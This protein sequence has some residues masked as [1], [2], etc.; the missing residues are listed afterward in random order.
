MDLL[1]DWAHDA[2]NRAARRE[3]L[4]SLERTSLVGGQVLKGWK[5]AQGTEL[6]TNGHLAWES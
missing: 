6:P 1:S 2:S 3:T 5:P 4:R